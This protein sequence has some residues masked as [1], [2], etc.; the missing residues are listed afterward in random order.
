M[1][2]N[3]LHIIFLLFCGASG[4]QVN[5]KITLKSAS[6]IKIG[7]AVSI[8]VLK[9]DSLCLPLLKR[10]F[11]SI[12]AENAMKMHQITDEK[13]NFKWQE[14]DYLVKLAND[15]HWRIHGHTLVWHEAIP[16]W[17]DKENIDSAKLEN[18]M[19][20]HI[21]TVISRYKSS[22]KSWDVVNEIFV[23]NSDS[24]RNSL[25][26]TT[27]GDEFACRAFKYAREAGGNDIK[28]FYNDFNNERIDKK[29]EASLKYFENCKKLGVTIDGIGFQMHVGLDEADSSSI[30]RNVL[31]AVNKGYL[32]HFSE[33]DISNDKQES[34]KVYT[35][36]F[37]LALSNRYKM[38]A[39][40][41]SKIPENQQFGITFW[42][43]HDGKTWLKSYFK[44]KYE[45]PLLFDEKYQ[46]KAAYYG[47]VKGLKQK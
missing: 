6:N 44:H 42:N 19:K 14:A 29:L 8:K 34:R 30:A 24:L 17:I 27:L 3:Y 21:Q 7:A 22:V 20:S 12:T 46:R 47:F 23:N 9:N 35:D 13:G 28:L 38:I 18:I 2:K 33:L 25:W 43:V 4:A 26:K 31:K 41:Y 40:V 5:D 11:S 32:I 10:E 37:A 39:S 36:S 45:W 15:N 16:K 1:K